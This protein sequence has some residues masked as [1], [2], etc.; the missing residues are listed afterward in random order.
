MELLNQIYIVCAI[1][2][3]LYL[4]GT[5]M[6]GFANADSGGGDS[7]D[8]GGIDAGDASGGDA[9]GID[10][11]DA[12][13]GDAGGIDAGDAS[14]GD[15]GGIDAADAGSGDFSGIDVGDIRHIQHVGRANGL[16]HA[17]TTHAQRRRRV[18][19]GLLLLKISSPYT[20]AC[21]AFFFGLVGLITLKYLPVFGAITL[22]P[23]SIAG[24]V[25]YII[26]TK[27]MNSLADKL[28]ASSSHKEEDV[29]GTVGELTI[30]IEPG[31]TGELIYLRGQTRHTVPAKAKDPTANL[32][33]T[34]K[35]MIADI[36]DGVFIV[37]PFSDLLLDDSI[38]IAE[39]KLRNS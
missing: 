34:S 10:A 27:M 32:A 35:V 6:L 5:A 3:F 15:V 14:G 12:S 21:F 4:V 37:E 11:G 19:V 24:V 18:H 39:Q 26:M 13:G 29:I 28:Y 8:A 2:G 30:P 1:G 9:G 23:A 7:G 25:G 36:V 22:I 38:T 16:A 33:K 17:G 20:V 31:R